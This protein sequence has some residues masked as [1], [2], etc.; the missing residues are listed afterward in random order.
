MSLQKLI[1]NYAAFNVWANAKIIDWVTTFDIEIIYKETP[2]SYNTIDKTLQHLLNAEKFWLAFVTNADTSNFKWGDLE[3]DF[4]IVCHQILETSNA[5]H[6]ACINFLENDLQE[7]LHLVRP[8]GSNSLSRYEYLMHVINHG[9][10][11]RGQIITMAR[12]LGCTA[13]VPGT[14]YNWFN[15]K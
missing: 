5:L 9:T 3:S 2:S 8:W 12:N 13:N 7:T 6:E 15:M 4:E 11:H 10:Y 1:T 14:D